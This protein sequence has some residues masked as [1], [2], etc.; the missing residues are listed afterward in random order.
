MTFKALVFVED[1]G[2]ANYGFPLVAPLKADLWIPESLAAYAAACGYAPTHLTQGPTAS[3]PEDVDVLLIGTSE[4]PETLAHDLVRQARE[5][6]IPSIGMIDFP[7]NPSNRFRGGTMI[8]LLHAPDWLMVTDQLTADRFAGLG[9]PADKIGI[10]GHPHFD[11]V[12]AFRDILKQE[13]KSAVRARLFPA[14]SEDQKIIVFLTEVS[15]GGYQSQYQRSKDYTLLGRGD[16]VDRTHIVLQEF[17]DATTQILPKPYRILRLHPKNTAAEFEPMTSEFDAVNAG[18]NPLEVVFGA[19]LV[20]GMNTMLLYEAAMLGKATLSILPRDGDAKL[21][22]TV[23]AGI[24]PYATTRPSL[25]RLLEEGLSRASVPPLNV[26]PA[27]DR[28]VDFVRM[29]MKHISSGAKH[30]NTH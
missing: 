17:L 21:T 8:P 22:P 6:G 13:G 3:L 25:L 15:G 5:R 11:K 28:A 2:A 26:A 14:V 1:P 23:V 4:N 16:R 30:A 29:L 7:A 9:F 12:L 27:L 18:G 19:D 10:V 20:C 24:T